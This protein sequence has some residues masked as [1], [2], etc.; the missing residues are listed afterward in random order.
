MTVYKSIEI[1]VDNSW[2]AFTCYCSKVLFAYTCKMMLLL[3]V[4]IDS[5]WC[6]IARWRMHFGHTWHL[7][8]ATI[9]TC[10]VDFSQNSI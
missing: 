9:T 4:I 5:T 8:L 7:L 3:N 2:N 1:H 6:Q 10:C